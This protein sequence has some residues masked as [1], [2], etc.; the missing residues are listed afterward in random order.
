[1]S[2][3]LLVLRHGKSDWSVDVSDFERPLKKRGKKAAQRMGAW[4][5]QQD[6]VP[7]YIMSSP[8][9]RALNTAEKLTKAM[10][11]TANQVHYDSRLYVAELKD[12][13]AVLADCPALG[14]PTS[15][16]SRRR[17]LRRH[18]QISP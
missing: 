9:E 17:A 7:D 10:G 18:E 11:L 12:L 2:R 13:Q 1:M 5:Q 14:R 6:L 4:L 16:S 15:T 3:Q 8:A